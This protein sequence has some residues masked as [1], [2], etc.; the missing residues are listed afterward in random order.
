MIKNDM[1]DRGLAMRD[2]TFD[3]GNTSW[4]ADPTATC[5][6]STSSRTECRRYAMLPSLS[7][8]R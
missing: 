5:P 4:I 7:V 1:D 8:L 2:Q 6:I 3:H